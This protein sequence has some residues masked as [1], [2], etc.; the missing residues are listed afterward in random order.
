MP[1]ILDT[2]DHF[3]MAKIYKPVLKYKTATML[4]SHETFS[5]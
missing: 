4:F 2:V 3:E 5:R 1:V